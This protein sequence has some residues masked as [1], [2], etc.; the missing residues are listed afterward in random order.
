MSI[1]FVD[2][3]QQS[4]LIC[5]NNDLKDESVKQYL[6]DK[7]CMDDDVQKYK[8]SVHYIDNKTKKEVCEDINCLP[9]YYILKNQSVYKKSSE[10]DQGYFYNGTKNSINKIGKL[11]IIPKEKKIRKLDSILFNRELGE[12]YFGSEEGKIWLINNIPWFASESTVLSNALLSDNQDEGLELEEIKDT[13]Q[14]TLDIILNYCF[15]IYNLRQFDDKNVIEITHIMKELYDFILVSDLDQN[16]VNSFVQ[17]LI[18]FKTLEKVIEKQDEIN[19]IINIDNYINIMSKPKIDFNR[20]ITDFIHDFNLNGANINCT[21]DGNIL[22]FASIDDLTKL[23]KEFD[24][25]FNLEEIE[26]TQEDYEY[27][28]SIRNYIIQLINES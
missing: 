21:S 27:L 14:N 16:L 24:K 10:I 12:L 5:K 11:V 13:K 22:L 28:V 1:Y 15:R 9:G 2:T 6:K 26:Y 19:S 3:N 25:E 23:L 7:F 17:E 8:F 20:E 18:F 4:Q